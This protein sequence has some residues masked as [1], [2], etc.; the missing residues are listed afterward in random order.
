MDQMQLEHEQIEAT[1]F[2]RTRGE[3]MA[4]RLYGSG[5]PGPFV[6]VV[7]GTAHALARKD[8]SWLHAMLGEALYDVPRQREEKK[9]REDLQKWPR[10]FREHLMPHLEGIDSEGRIYIPGVMR[11]DDEVCIPAARSQGRPSDDF[12]WRDA[13]WE[14]VR[15]RTLW[16]TLVPAADAKTRLLLFLW[17]HGIRRIDRNALKPIAMQFVANIAENRRAEISSVERSIERT[18]SQ[19]ERGTFASG[20]RAGQAHD[21]RTRLSRE[22]RLTR[23]TR[24]LSSL[25]NDLE[26]CEWGL[27]NPIHYYLGIK[28]RKARAWDVAEREEALAKAA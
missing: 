3:D 28:S 5:A 16:P 12:E 24:Y 15:A 26:E 6:V 23:L 27:E 2:E 21:A 13:F 10:A 4:V 25:R 8:I 18:K 14:Y 17:M 11:S 9:W 20:L 1:L 19:L 22:G 7:E